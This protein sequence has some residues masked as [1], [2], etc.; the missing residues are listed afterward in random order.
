VIG[1]KRFEFLAFSSNQLRESVVWMFASNGIV[2]IDNIRES[3]GDIVYTRD[4]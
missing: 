2:D 1:N 4:S 3:M